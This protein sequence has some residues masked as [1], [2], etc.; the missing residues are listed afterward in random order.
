MGHSEGSITSLKSCRLVARQLMNLYALG[1]LGDQSLLKYFTPN[2]SYR[3]KYHV[4]YS[5]FYL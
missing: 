3:I 2:I 4:P 1:S 5:R